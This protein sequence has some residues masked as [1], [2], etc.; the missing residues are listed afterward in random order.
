MRDIGT[1]DRNLRHDRR[2]DCGC[3]AT[4]KRFQRI[5]WTLFTAE[6]GRASE[7][8]MVIGAVMAG[9]SDEEWRFVERM[10]AASDWP[11]DPGR[12][13][14]CDKQPEVL[15]KPVLS[16]EKCKTTM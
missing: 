13:P 11:S 4:D 6:D 2:S 16:D 1:E 3:G 9:A 8:A 15:G 10:V 12:Y 5:S 7:A 14:G